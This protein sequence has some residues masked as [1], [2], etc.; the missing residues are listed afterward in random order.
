MNHSTHSQ[1][2]SVHSRW[3]EQNTVVGSGRVRE[4][5]ITVPNLRRFYVCGPLQATLR[6]DRG[7]VDDVLLRFEADDAVLPHLQARI[8]AGI[9]ELSLKPGVYLDLPQ[10]RVHATVGNLCQVGT[11]GTADV[12]VRGLCASHVA[13]ACTGRSRLRASGGS[14]EWTVH[15]G[16]QGRAQLS[17]RQASRA[18]LDLTKASQVRLRGRAGVLQVRGREA[19]QLVAAAPACRAQCADVDLQG[20][21]RATLYAQHR[22]AGRVRRPARLD[23]QCP[24]R[25][26][27]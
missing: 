7:H 18:T 11:A 20:A 6:I 24:G 10:P 27:L 8:H 5:L 12:T 22:V 17:L 9:V 2:A 21:S 13:L 14:R 3:S 1:D 23:A 19:A 25:V 15:A 26:E 4:R 16:G